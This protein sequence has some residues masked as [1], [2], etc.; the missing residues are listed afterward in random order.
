MMSKIVSSTIAVRVGVRFSGSRFFS[1]ASVSAAPRAAGG[2]RIISPAGPDSTSRFV[3]PLRAPATPCESPFTWTDADT[4]NG[5]FAGYRWR[6][7]RKSDNESAVIGPAVR[8]RH[9]RINPQA[10]VLIFQSYVIRE[11]VIEYD[12]MML[13]WVIA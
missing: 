3:E 4:T 1:S 11:V 5:A 12:L 10:V 6:T 13:P 9:A 8:N 7:A 2:T